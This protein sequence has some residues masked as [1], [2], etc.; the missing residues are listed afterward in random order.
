MFQAD[1]LS[2]QE[3]KMGEPLPLARIHE[4]VLGFLQ[5]RSDAVLFGA[6]AVNAYVSEPRMTQDIDILTTRA[7]E[8][9]VELQRFLHDRFHIAVRQCKVAQGRGFR[10][11]QSTATGN[12]HL[13]DLQVVSDLPSSERIAGVLVLAVPELLARKVFAYHRRRGQPKSGSDWRDIAELLL[14]YPELK[15]VDGDVAERIHALE[16]R[17]EVL[18]TWREF[19]ALDLRGDEDD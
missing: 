12:R 19:V 7:A 10:L 16:P 13:V 4:A 1:V 8:L 2:F 14:A 15:V 6:H 5:E 18:D 3:F 9:A 17:P 11:Y